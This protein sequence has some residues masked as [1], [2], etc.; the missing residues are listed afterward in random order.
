M[1]KERL[2]SLMTVFALVMVHTLGVAQQAQ[3]LASVKQQ[4]LNQKVIVI[5]YVAA[6]LAPEPVLMHWNPASESAGRYSMNGLAYLPAT[7]KGKTAT[8]I[9]IQLDDLTKQGK[10]N[11]LGEPISPDD[12]VDPH[13]DIVVRFED[14]QIAMT[15]AYPT[16][17]SEEMRLAAELNTVAQEMAANLPKVVGKDLFACGFTKLYSPDATL[18]E[19]MGSSA[20]LK[21]ISDVPFLVPLKVTAAKYN[22]T[23]D[24]V[25]LKVKLPDG[26]DALAITYPERLTDKDESFMERISSSLLTAIPTKFTPR[27]VAAIKKRSI[28]RGMTEGALVYT[29]G[30]AKSENDWG[31]GGKQFVY[32]DTLTVYLDNQDKVVDW[33][34]LDNK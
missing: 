28:F 29:L 7:Y 13:L 18:D 2:R 31:R 32:T 30:S 23:S 10:L 5:G 15:T 34:A 9:V 26:R 14:D 11:A 24:A 19:M 6:T 25:I 17:I 22:E 16:T 21:Q 4:Y 3:T 20:I 27:E 12:A 33:Q 8:V 1:R